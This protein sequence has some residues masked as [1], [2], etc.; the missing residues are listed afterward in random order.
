MRTGRPP[1]PIEHRFWSKV[2]FQGHDG[3]WLF[4]G[5]SMGDYGV[6]KHKSGRHIKAHRFA[7]ETFHGGIPEGLIVCHRCDVPMCCNPEHLF[8]GT[9]KDNS[10]DKIKKGRAVACPGERNGA[11]KLR[12]HQVNEIR[13]S[14]LQQRKLAE[15]FNVSPSCISMIKRGVNW[16]ASS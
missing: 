11:A 12:A 16:N 10:D 3:C 9:H 1:T 14:D 8:L 6:I 4:T 15:M 13:A 7:W 2:S 5:A